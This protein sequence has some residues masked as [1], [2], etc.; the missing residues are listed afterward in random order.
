MMSTYNGDKYLREQIESI[1]SQVGVKVNLIVRDDGST[2][3]TQKILQ[4]YEAEGKLKWYAGKNIGAAYS[5]LNLLKSI[6]RDE[7]YAFSDQD[8]VWDK[9]KLLAGIS[10]LKEY[11]EEAIVLYTCSVRVVSSNLSEIGSLN[12]S[13]PVTTFMDGMIRNNS[14]GC[15]MVFGNVLRNLLVMYNGKNLFMHDDLAV[16]VCLAMG[17]IIYR[18]V[19]KYIN[20]RQHGNNV[21]GTQEP[22]MRSLSRRAKSLLNQ[23][24]E[25][26][27]ELQDII[28]TYSDLI[29]VEN[30]YVMEKIAYYKS[31][32]F[33]RIAILI[34]R[35][36]VSKDNKTTRRFKLGILMGFF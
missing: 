4:E 10:K 9:K 24:C 26:S 31:R 18:D 5:F 34:S 22:F 11:P 1:L 14:Q 3:N 8:D 32:K 19:E 35:N 23:S 12:S 25:R 33:G 27:K 13:V 30:R 7:F 15:T 20:Y 16:K 36:I 2:D 21:I 29:P 6:S 28:E 17:G